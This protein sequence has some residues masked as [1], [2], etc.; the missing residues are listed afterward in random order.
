MG[1]VYAFHGQ[2]G[3][4]IAIS[5]ADQAMAGPAAGALIGT[6]V[7]NLGPVVG[8]LANVGVGNPNDRLDFPGA[9]GCAF[10]MSGGAGLGPLTNKVVVSQPQPV[11]LVGP[12]ILGGGLSGTDAAL[13]LI[14][15]SHP[16]VLVV[17]E[18]VGYLT[19][20]DGNTLPAPP[21][22][23][24]VQAA[25]QVVL[26]LPNGWS[27]GPDGGSLIKDING[28]NHPDFALRGGGSPGKIAVYY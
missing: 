18:Q 26:S 28:D 5:S 16:D 9:V 14:G 7:S 25:A 21:A 15:D 17:A 22:S 4:S 23:L 1:H 19:I 13:S 20:T 11:N 27:I 12:V 24:N 2:G 6:F 8:T 10:V 3:S